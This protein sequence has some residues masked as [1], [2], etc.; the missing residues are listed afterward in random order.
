MHYAVPYEYERAHESESRSPIPSFS[1]H[2]QLSFRLPCRSPENVPSPLPLVS[3]SFN[4][5]IV[6]RL[7]ANLS[8]TF[9]I[10]SG[11]H[12]VRCVAFRRLDERGGGRDL[13]LVRYER[14]TMFLYV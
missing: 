8:L 13:T 14:N 5:L 1:S 10:L 3:D 7:H 9:L 4:R 2:P 11:Y 12:V 6:S